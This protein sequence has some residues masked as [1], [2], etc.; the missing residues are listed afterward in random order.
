MPADLACRS[1]LEGAQN[2]LDQPLTLTQAP[3]TDGGEGFCSI[4][5]NAVNGLIEYHTV[6]GPLGEDLSAPLGWVNSLDIPTSA[7]AFLGKESERLAVIEMASV[8]GLEQ[9]PSE[10][11][12]RHWR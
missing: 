3:L 11:T 7:R 4:L 12:A 9:V 5:T 8:A 2:A 10:N 6:S 1:A